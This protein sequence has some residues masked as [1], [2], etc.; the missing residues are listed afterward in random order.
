MRTG[1]AEHTQ[2]PLSVISLGWIRASQPVHARVAVIPKDIELLTA[3]DGRAVTLCFGKQCGYGTQ[4]E[5]ICL[6]RGAGP[7]IGRSEKAPNPPRYGLVLLR[8]KAGISMSSRLGRRTGKSMVLPLP[9]ELV[10]VAI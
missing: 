7:R 5:R 9:P 10:V 1:E 2:P 8:K 3:M 4:R 6:C